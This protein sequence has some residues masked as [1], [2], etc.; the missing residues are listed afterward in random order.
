MPGMFCNCPLWMLA[1]VAVLIVSSAA[2]ADSAAPAPTTQPGLRVGSLKVGRVLVIGNS[3]TLHGPK[4]EIGWT[5]R[6]G[7]AASTQAKDFVHVLATRIAAAAGTQP[8][9]RICGGVP[10]EHG[11]RTIDVR[12][13]LQP[14]TD[15]APDL[16]VL[17]IGENVPA[18]RTE[19]DRTDYR[20]AL[21]RL[22][23]ELATLGQPV[24]FARSAFWAEGVRDGILKA[25]C[26]KAGAIYVDQSKLGGDE[27]NYARSERAFK[28]A[29]VAAHPG[30]RG[31]EAIA[32][33]L[34]QAIRAKAGLP[35][36]T[37]PATP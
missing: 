31:M 14:F 16:V 37:Q 32:D 28:H 33:S 10:F 18:L 22:F 9:V 29:G 20:A 1:A 3:I 5:D 12:V 27:R 19:Q 36:G 15:F 4:P 8:D 7:M 30:D 2:W 17:A 35:A 24:I 11:Y 34:W 26:Q 13:M 6:W 25:A 21:D 23:A